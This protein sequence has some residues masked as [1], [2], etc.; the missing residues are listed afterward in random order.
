MMR[1]LICWLI[2]AVLLVGTAGCGSDTKE[3]P[4]KNQDSSKPPQ[5][6]QSKDVRKAAP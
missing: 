1:L 2:P 5:Q 6:Q 3:Q 4:A